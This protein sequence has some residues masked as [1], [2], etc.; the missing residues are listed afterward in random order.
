MNADHKEFLSGFGYLC[1]SEGTLCSK[2][3]CSF[4]AVVL[5][6]LSV[7][8]KFWKWNWN[9]VLHLLC[10]CDTNRNRSDTFSLFVKAPWIYWRR[11]Y[12]LHTIMFLCASCQIARIY[13]K[14][15]VLQC[16]SKNNLL[17]EQRTKPSNTHQQW[18]NV[19]T[20]RYHLG[21]SGNQLIKL[22]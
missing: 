5:R 13:K 11:S 15:A 4:H 12:A 3:M 7:S 21:D 10:Y 8:R 17:D 16:I 19:S 2:R 22:K 20:D 9:Y 1:R 14:N 18:A 6:R